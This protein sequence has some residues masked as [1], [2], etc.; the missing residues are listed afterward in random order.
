MGNA[1]SID[2]DDARRIFDLAVDSPL[3]CSGNFETEDVV[4]LRR[5][6]AQIGA[7]PAAATP[8]LFARDFPHAFVPF[9]V[10][11]ERNEITDPAAR[12]GQR[13][14]TDEEVYAR[15]GSSPDRCE[16][17][18]YSRRCAQPAADQI[19]EGS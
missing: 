4:V 12:F 16:A 14:E 18:A 13:W 8:D 5:F 15:L 11:L 2:I 17:G 9:D 19:H 1:V 3:V 6:A 7:D 10:K